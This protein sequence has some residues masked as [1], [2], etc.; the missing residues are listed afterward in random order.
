LC[1]DFDS[2]LKVYSKL[3]KEVDEIYVS[4]ACSKG[5]EIFS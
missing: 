1:E 4:K 2:A 5:V 3:S